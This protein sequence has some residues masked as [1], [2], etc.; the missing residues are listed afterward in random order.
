MDLAGNTVLITGA[1]SGIGLAF[2]ERFLAAG[3]TVIICGRREALLEEVRAKHPA[4]HT[5]PCDVRLPEQRVALRDHVLAKFPDLN[6][7]VN[8]AGVQRQI[9]DLAPEAD[10]WSDAWSEV[11]INVGAVFHLVSLFLPHLR[12]T[13]RAAIA[14]VTSG[15]SF[16]PKVNV[17]VYSATKA[18]VHSFTLSLREQ[19][20][21]RGAAEGKPPVRV[22]E[23][24]PPAVNTD[25]G[26]PG[27]H[28]FGVPL[29]AYA[30]SVMQDL[31]AGH[32]TVFYGLSAKM[33]AAHGEE[34]Q[35]LFGVVN[36]LGK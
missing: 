25:L 2:A 14:N 22:I 30:D 13:P 1:T 4:I 10:K 17:P 15:L 9:D 35:R 21:L 5:V 26:G 24:V 36:A 16:I 12:R 23:I 8:N 28:T 34:W 29:D 27:L 32:D 7:L 6:V 19:E 3:S 20:R 31:A 18:A 33:A 11:E